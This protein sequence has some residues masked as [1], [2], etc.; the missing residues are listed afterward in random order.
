MGFYEKDVP[1]FGK[2]MLI[3]EPGPSCEKRVSDGEMGWAEGM[4]YGTGALF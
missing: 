2:F 3:R 4:S 1:E